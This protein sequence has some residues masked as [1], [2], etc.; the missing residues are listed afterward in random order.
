[1]ASSEESNIRTGST[2]YEWRKVKIAGSARTGQHVG[3][4]PGRFS[5]L[6][7]RN[8]TARLTVT[9]SHK[10][11]AESWWL[12]EARGRSAVFPGHRGLDD[13]MAEI[14]REFEPPR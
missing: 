11:G 13:V 14:N 2:T 4:K 7:R 12:I 3:R 5:G 10:G 9:I 6:S 8:R 1:M